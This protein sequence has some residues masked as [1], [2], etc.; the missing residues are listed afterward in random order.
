MNLCSSE[1]NLDSSIYLDL[2]SLSLYRELVVFCVD[3]LTFSNLP[4]DSLVV[5]G[6]QMTDRRSIFRSERGTDVCSDLRRISNLT[7]GAP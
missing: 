7:M 5:D 4:S 2:Y 1:Q 3:I 6:G